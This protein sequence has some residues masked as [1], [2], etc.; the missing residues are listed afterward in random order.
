MF[1]RRWHVF[2]RSKREWFLLGSPFLTVITIFM[3]LFCLFKVVDKRG[4]VSS[5]SKETFS[6]VVAALFPFFLNI[7]YTTASGAFLLMPID[8]RVTKMKHI[9]TMS[10]MRIFSYWIG[11]LIADFCLFLIPTFGFAGLISSL[12]IAGYYD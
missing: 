9:I 2:L 4:G 6:T 12:N 7:G 5:E 1:I 3:L 11:L 10:G 8:E